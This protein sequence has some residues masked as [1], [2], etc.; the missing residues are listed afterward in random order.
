MRERFVTRTITAL[1]VDCLCVNKETAECYNDSFT[2]TGVTYS[3]EK[4][5]VK[6]IE[7]QIPVGSPVK[8]VDVVNVT[9]VSK[10]Y[11]LPESLFIEYSNAYEG[12]EANLVGS[13]K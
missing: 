10:L 4:K 9:R 2:V 6:M 12:T 13:E 8:V 1:T 3:D 7:R 11:K 5:M